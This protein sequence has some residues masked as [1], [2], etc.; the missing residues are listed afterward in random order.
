MSKSLDLG[1][2]L[3]SIKGEAMDIRDITATI[4]K[5]SGRQV[6]KMANESSSAQ[7][8]RRPFG[9]PSL[10]IHIG[11]GLPGGGP[12]MLEGKDGS[13]K[14]ALSWQAIKT[15]QWVYGE[16]AMVLWVW[17]E[18]PPD[19]TH[20]RIIGAACPASDFEVEAESQDRLNKGWSPL[21]EEQILDRKRQVGEFV[22]V[23]EG[24]AE[25]R[26]EV[27]TDLVELNQFQLIIIDSIGAIAAKEI[28][29]TRLGKDA[30][31]AAIAAL[32][33]NFQ[34]KLWNAFS[35]PTEGC[36]EINFT[37]MLMLNQV[38]AKQDLS[39]NPAIAN[40]QRKDQGNDAYAIKHGKLVS[41]LS[42]SGEPIKKSNT[43]VGKQIQI[44][45]LKGKA[46]CHE[47]GKGEIPYLYSSGFDAA[48]DLITNLRKRKLLIDRKTKVDVIDQYGEIILEGA[49]H[50][51]ELAE[52]KEMLLEDPKLH[53][54]LYQE[55]MGS[56]EGISCLYRL[57]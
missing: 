3:S 11:G 30:R 35:C 21:S 41:I 20:A 32:Q 39:P 57:G 1:C 44:E 48:T 49:P 53:W 36:G 2:G 28:I 5:E 37:T 18:I 6:L 17:L 8:L 25:D 55:L 4:N 19:K 9:L 56:V 43:K 40:R 27:T 13:G 34:R 10:D 29:D 22:V 23:G 33:S 26:L 46:G 42:K 38:R 54:K 52:F 47:G 31:R 7:I 14:N 15:L 12:S 51:K 50:G 45:V 24:S 16:E